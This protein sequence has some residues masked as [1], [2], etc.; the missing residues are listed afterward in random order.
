MLIAVGWDKESSDPRNMVF[1]TDKDIAK[2]QHGL[3]LEA[4]GKG[5]GFPGILILAYAPTI[6]DAEALLAP[7]MDV[8]TLRLPDPP[9]STR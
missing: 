6:E 2:I 3:T 5:F 1:I 4:D 7:A 9:N 8:G